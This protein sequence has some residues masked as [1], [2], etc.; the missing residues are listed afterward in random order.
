MKIKELF[1]EADDN[2]CFC[3]VCLLSSLQP[4]SLDAKFFHYFFGKCFDELHSLVTPVKTIIYKTRHVIS[5]VFRIKE[6][7]V[8]KELLPCGTNSY[9]VPSLLT[10]IFIYWIH[11][12]I[13][14]YP[15]YPDNLHFLLYFLTHIFNNSIV[16]ITS[17]IRSLLCEPRVSLN[18]VK[19]K[20]F[21]L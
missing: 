7:C 6:D 20:T 13:V 4:I 18:L 21:D 16:I 5:S 1:L 8:S 17:S 10:L 9:L 19:K 14:I 15:L 11:G 3:G 12:S 2:M